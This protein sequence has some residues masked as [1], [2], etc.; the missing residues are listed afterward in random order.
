MA[1]KVTG[2]V[3]N[4]KSAIAIFVTVSRSSI[5]ANVTKNRWTKISRSINGVLSVDFGMLRRLITIETKKS[6]KKKEGI[7]DRMIVSKLIELLEIAE[8]R[9]VKMDD[10]S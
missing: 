10:A 2:S 1:K 6:A 8:S 5:A 9:K 7:T 4:A 3:S